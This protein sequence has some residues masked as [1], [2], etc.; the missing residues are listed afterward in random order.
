MMRRIFLFLSLICVA[1]IGA[2][3]S[4]LGI[5]ED[6]NFPVGISGE[7]DGVHRL[8]VIN[9]ELYAATENGIYKYSESTNSWNC[10][11][12]ENVNVMDFKANGDEVMAIIVPQDKKGFRAVEMA[13]LIRFNHNQSEWED[14]M[15]TGMGYFYYDQFLTYVM[16]LAQHPSKPQTLMVAAYPGIWISEDFGTTWSFKSGRLY[17]YNEHQ[18]LGWHPANDNVLFYTS[19]SPIFAAQIQRSENGGDSWDIINPDPTGDNSCHHLAFDPDNADHILY[20]G[21]ECIFESDDCGRTWLCVYRQDDH[22]DETEIGYAYNVMFDP[23]NAN[24]VYSVGSCSIHQDIHIFKS[25][26]KGKTWARIAR[27]DLFDNH[28]YWPHESV[29]FKGKI[30]LYTHNGVL[31]YDLGNN[32]GVVTTVDDNNDGTGSLY[33]LSGRKVNNPHT[34]T[35]YIQRGKKIIVK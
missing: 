32:S 3:A 31:T 30:Y 27:S 12:L 23:A 28:E 17:G 26:D 29:L 21:E 22:K 19:E 14:V 33:D 25:A 6:T 11:A 35:I 2:N 9:G 18:F 15:D 10:W 34:G 5:F 16:R 8:E 7:S 13:K 1:A 4:V 24:I 20:S